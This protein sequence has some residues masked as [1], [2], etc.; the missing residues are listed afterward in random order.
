LRHFATIG[1]GGS[2]DIALA[3]DVIRDLQTLGALDWAQGSLMMSDDELN[4]LFDDLPACEA[5]A[6]EEY[7]PAWIP[8]RGHGSDNDLVEGDVEQNV[9]IV[10]TVDEENGGVVATAMSEDAAVATFE[11]K[12]ALSRAASQS[13]RAS[14]S[15]K[16]KA[17]YKIA[18]SFRG[19]E[20]DTV[21]MVLGER[22]AEKLMAICKDLY[23]QMSE[24]EKN[25]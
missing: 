9:Q 16:I 17:P 6:G 14:L 19:D 12:D 3:N 23:D 7:D 22:P 5:L 24:S 8:E 18:F 2:E 20:A 10:E 15:K 25:G 4:D 1:L 21:R 11:R 13:E